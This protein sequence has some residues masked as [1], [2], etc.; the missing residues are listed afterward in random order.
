MP[1]AFRTVAAG[2]GSWR[3]SKINLQHAAFRTGWK[4][5]IRT[6]PSDVNG[7]GAILQQ[8]DVIRLAEPYRDLWRFQ[9]VPT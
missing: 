8:M 6:I 4:R 2:L 9:A 5:L 7:V 3:M 1:I